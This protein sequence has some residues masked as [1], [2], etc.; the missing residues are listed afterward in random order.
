MI[1][2]DL[3]TPLP[4]IP[5]PCALTIGCFDGVHLGHQHLLQKL[6][7]AGYPVVFT[8]TNH[9]LEVIKKESVPVLCTLKHKLQL[10]KQRGVQHVLLAT[11][12]PALAT[13][14]YV[15]FFKDLKKTLP[16]SHLILGKGAALGKGRE[17]NEERVQNLCK[18]L[19]FQVTYL[20]KMCVN[21][22]PISSGRIREQI[23]AGNL[24]EVA[25]LLG[26]PYSIYS[27][28][29]TTLRGV[30]TQGLCQLPPGKY[31]IS[32]LGRSGH[33]EIMPGIACLTLPHFVP[34]SLTPIEIFFEEIT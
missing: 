9:P 31:P 32:C 6:K 17:G 15:D 3:F 20:D 2:S 11:F 28:Y 30:S 27:L 12:T 34:K 25:Q 29:D 10:L 16:F 5:Q 8:F 13:Q 24:K 23:Q 21:G 14:T 7:E 22:A 26:R 4:Q 1:V 33:A 18:E 19:S